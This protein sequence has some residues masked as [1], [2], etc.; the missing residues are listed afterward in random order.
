M[1]SATGFRTTL[2]AATLKVLRAWVKAFLWI[3]VLCAV[4]LVW[5]VGKLFIGGELSWGD[6]P[7]ALMRAG[8]TMLLLALKI[9]GVLLLA[10]ILIA[11]PI[12]LLIDRKS[13]GDS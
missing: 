5:E 1:T 8:P 11:V 13:R 3:A 6:L 9:S 10:S 7:Q 2:G 12:V 4:I